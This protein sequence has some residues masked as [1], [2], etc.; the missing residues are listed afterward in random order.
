MPLIT[1]YLSREDYSEF[2]ERVKQSG[3]SEG[4]LSQN[5]IVD[6]LRAKIGKKGRVESE[7]DGKSVVK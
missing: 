2:Q 5:L 3:K 7:K 4:K 1:T 6:F